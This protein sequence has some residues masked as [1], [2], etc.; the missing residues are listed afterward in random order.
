MS[1]GETHRLAAVAS[2]PEGYDSLSH[3]LGRKRPQMEAKFAS[4]VEIATVAVREALRLALKNEATDRGEALL[5]SFSESEG[6]I[7]QCPE[8]A[9]TGIRKTKVGEL[10]RVY[11][12]FH[13]A[14]IRGS[15][16]EALFIRVNP[17][18]ESIGNLIFEE[19]SEGFVVARGN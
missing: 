10:L 3:I 9:W 18:V 7:E 5:L 16:L 14:K 11:L 2:A 12:N 19:N 8:V 13:D 4:A 6:E 1:A 15:V 17:S